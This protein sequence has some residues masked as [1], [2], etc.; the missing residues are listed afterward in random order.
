[1]LC[2]SFFKSDW[3]WRGENHEHKIITGLLQCYTTISFSPP[4]NKICSVST[5]HLYSIKSFYIAK[6]RNTSSPILDDKVIKGEEPKPKTA[7]RLT[8]QKSNGIETKI[9][10][11]VVVFQNV[12]RWRCAKM[13][14]ELNLKHMIF[15]N[16]KIK[17]GLL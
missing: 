4:L 16:K 13:V 12:P 3:I 14:L 2:T 17:N 7:A 8:E 5:W 11:D 1:M 10:I 9:I 6:H 15:I